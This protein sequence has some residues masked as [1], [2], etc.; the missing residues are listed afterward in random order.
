MTTAENVKR[1]KKDMKRMKKD[2]RAKRAHIN[3]ADQIG[4]QVKRT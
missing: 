1:D 2:E 3:T 4:R